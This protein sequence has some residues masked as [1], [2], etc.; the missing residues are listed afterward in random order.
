MKISTDASIYEIKPK[1]VIYPVN[2]NDLI[3]TIRTL[4]SGNQTFTMRAGGTSTGGQAIGKGIL[5]DVSKYLTNI[6]FFNKTVIS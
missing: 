3:S 1:N 5:V 2:R 6:L 4:L